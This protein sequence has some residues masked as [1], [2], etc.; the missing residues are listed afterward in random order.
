M[1]QI[2]LA[3]ILSVGVG[4]AA[5]STDIRSPESVFGHPVGADRKLV[6]YPDVLEYLRTVAAASD[7]VS[8]EVAGTS[9]LSVRPARHNRAEAVLQ[10][11]LTEN[12]L[13]DVD[14]LG[15][16]TGSLVR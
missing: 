7:R 6:P 16:W 11:P 5:A 2:L 4:V 3:G 12:W 10:A 15:R 13:P 1:R 9:T 14:L 8:I